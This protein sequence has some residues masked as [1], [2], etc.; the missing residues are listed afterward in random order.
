MDT[1]AETRNLEAR[2]GICKLDQYYKAPTGTSSSDP[3]VQQSVLALGSP[4]IPLKEDSFESQG[5]LCDI[6]QEKYLFS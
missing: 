1:E 4:C 5:S 3:V 2:I 6:R